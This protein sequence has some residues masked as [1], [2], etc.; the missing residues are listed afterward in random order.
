VS[1]AMATRFAAEFRAI[2]GTPYVT[3]D[4]AELQ[5]WNI[6]EVTPALAVTPA[7]ADEVGGILRFANEHGLSVVPAGGFTQQQTGNLP[8]QVD[9]LLF[10]S[11]LTAVDHYD[12]GDL[13]VGVG[14]GCTVAQLSAMVAE[15]GLLFAADPAQPERCT[16]GG[17]LATGLYGPLRHGYGGL[18]DYCI[19]VRFVTGDGRKAKG[20]GRVV[21]NVA[22]YDMMKLLIGS[23]GTLGVITGASFKLFPAARQMRT[24]VA[25]FPTAGKAVEFR[26]RVLHSP[27]A[28]IC[29]EI[30]SP[31]APALLS[32]A[33]Q[34][35][36]GSWSM[37][38]RAA[39]SDAV[40][41]RYRA[42]LGGAISREIEGTRESDLWRA[43]TDFAPIA[44][45]RHPCS[46]LISM[47][48]PVGDVPGALTKLSTAAGTNRFYFA[49]IGRV[50]V[51][52]LLAS[53]WQAPEAETSL[54]GFVNTVSALRNHLPRDISMAVL[55]CPSESRHHVSA[56]GPM[57]TDMESMRAVKMT[58]DPRDILNRG[59]FLF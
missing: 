54:V 19:G 58:L 43:L 5:A 8:Q 22:G 17:L 37:L 35:D 32:I 50:G 2:C 15:N 6:M 27:L 31:E 14:A 24:F 16:I 33:D 9:V 11:R 41:G 56:W 20:G 46:L 55:R 57:P 29:M 10:T 7:S 39:G 59:R 21:K 13:T 51:G 42:E 30:V 44:A 1:T 34:A 18:R 38:V 25:D 52:H 28:P 53:L 3:E 40:L 26:N 48:L 49:A 36:A 12:A 4:P 45:E 23:Q 47:T